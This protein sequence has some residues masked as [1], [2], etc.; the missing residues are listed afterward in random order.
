M[1]ILIACGIGLAWL[2]V[3]A[4]CAA[5]SAAD[6]EMERFFTLGAAASGGADGRHTN[7]APA[8]AATNTTVHSGRGTDSR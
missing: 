1:T 6:R 8:G 5:A 3:L 7:Q 2:F 4:L